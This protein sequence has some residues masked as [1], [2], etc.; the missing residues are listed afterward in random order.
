MLQ[1]YGN[2]YDVE[3]AV[4]ESNADISERERDE[5]VEKFSRFRELYTETSLCHT[6]VGNMVEVREDYNFSAYDWRLKRTFLD[7]D[8]RP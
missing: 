6:F 8:E 1:G 7:D 3:Q 5:I 4:M 2:I